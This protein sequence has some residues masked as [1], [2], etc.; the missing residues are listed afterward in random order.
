MNYVPKFRGRT[1]FFVQSEKKCTA[2]ERTLMALL[3]CAACIFVCIWI[4]YHEQLLE[5]KAEQQL[6]EF[7]NAFVRYSA[8]CG[9]LP[10]SQQ[11]I[12]ALFSKPV[13]D[14]VPQNWKGPY[15]VNLSRNN[16]WGNRIV[17][18]TVSEGAK[19]EFVVLS[20]SGDG[21]CLEL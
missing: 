20:Y 13:L 12:E 19:E 11:G 21:S 15:A 16:P 7:K 4:P 2:V 5:K 3:F 18:R 1:C 9:S 8:D 14:P 6:V 10:T 17:Y